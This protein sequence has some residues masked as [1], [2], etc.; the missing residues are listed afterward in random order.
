MDKMRI[1]AKCLKRAKYAAIG[2]LGSLRHDALSSQ[3]YSGETDGEKF[4]VFDEAEDILL[5]CFERLDEYL[6]NIEE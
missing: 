2:E 1:V 3:R 6:R 5:R 4:E